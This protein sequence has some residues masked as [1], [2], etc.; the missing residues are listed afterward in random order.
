[1]RFV[2]TLTIL[3]CCVFHQN[4]QAQFHTPGTAGFLLEECK[5]T[6]QNSESLSSAHN[7]YCGAFTEGYIMGLMLTHQGDMPKPNT[8]DPCRIDKEKAFSHINN[9]Y[10]T[11]FPAITP[12]NTSAGHMIEIIA[13]IIGAWANHNPS[14]LKYDVVSALEPMLA[15]G[16]FCQNINAEMIDSKDTVL[17]VNN[18]LKKISW[19][20][21][22]SA[23]SL[24]SLDNKNMQCLA[25]IKASGGNHRAFKATK[26]GGEILGFITG[27]SSSNHL[28]MNRVNATPMCEK[29]IQRVYEG[30]NVSKTMC[31]HKNTDPLLVARVFT[32][33]YKL[34]K[35]KPKKEWG[36]ADLFDAGDL[37]AVGYETIYR[38]FLCRNEAELKAAKQRR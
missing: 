8:S 33:N 24:V 23:K 15:P 3:F 12:E 36:W 6:L 31:V 14:L 29:P 32:Q 2:F 17:P 30:F 11:R 26:C 28:L 25:D 18:K 19:A 21:L 16:Q 38:G 20:D 10:C 34:I 4:A 35:G 13:N 22:L 1:M 9:R 7:S 37:G 5:K 27:V